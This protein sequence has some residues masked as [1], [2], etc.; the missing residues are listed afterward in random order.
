MFNHIMH[1]MI[2][3]SMKNNIVT[4]IT[5]EIY[6]YDF[7]YRKCTWVIGFING[8]KIISVA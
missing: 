4:E 1:L 8:T 3:T 7:M 6:L 2:D 5:F